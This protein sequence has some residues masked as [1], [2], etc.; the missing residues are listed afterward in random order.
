MT[1]VTTL[2]PRGPFLLLDV[3]Q[4]MEAQVCHT[5]PVLA[6]SRSR[7]PPLGAP[8]PYQEL[9]TSSKP[10]CWTPG[11]GLP[12]A[13]PGPDFCRGLPPGSSPGPWGTQWHLVERTLGIVPTLTC[14]RVGRVA[15][16]RKLWQE[17]GTR[18]PTRKCAAPQASTGE[19]AGRG[20]VRQAVVC[21]PVGRS[22]LSSRAPEAGAPP[23]TIRAG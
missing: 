18:T 4:P 23:T 19:G 6:Q 8:A 16:H 2:V 10:I 22:I 3:V 9:P 21:A 14:R 20:E 12:Q 7:S 11:P 15:G 17:P 1:H 5:P 13:P